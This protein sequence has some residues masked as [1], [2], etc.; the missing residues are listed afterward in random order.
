MSTNWEDKV[1]GLKKAAMSSVSAEY[2]EAAIATIG[3]VM[4]GKSVS[5]GKS[6][7]EAAARIVFNIPSAHVE[8]VLRDGYKNRYDLK[9]LRQ[10]DPPPQTIDAR[11]Q[12]D[13]VLANLAACQPHEVYYGAV[14]LNGAG[15]RYYGDLS[16]VLKLET[17]GDPDPGATA[18][19]PGPLILDR[20]SFDLIC[21][22]IR[23]RTITTSVSGDVWNSGVA[24]DE[25]C[26][27]SGRF[28]SDLAN[29][30]TCKV[31]DGAGSSERRLTVGGVS[32]GVLSDEDYIEVIRVGSFTA[33]DVDEVRA[34]AADVAAEGIIADRLFH[35]PMPDWTE[36][37][38]RHRRRGAERVLASK[39]IRRR[40]VVSSG[41][42]R[43]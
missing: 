15:V 20:N 19:D 27:R 36:L 6:R 5:S 22:P 3:D 13:N 37:L 7:P 21:E 42:L 29:I 30:A 33:G 35:G 8:A 2:R 41:R 12:I 31:L 11:E 38:W 32:E 18:D 25:A 43:S 40:T 28:R 4:S 10:G 14:E 9:S 1:A 16:F 24:A 26:E 17:A 39:G 34:T 23:S